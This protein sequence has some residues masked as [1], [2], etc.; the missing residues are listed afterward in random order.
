MLVEEASK[1]KERD[2]VACDMKGNMTKWA[3]EAVV[4]CLVF[5]Y[6]LVVMPMLSDSFYNSFGSFMDLCWLCPCLL[7]YICFRVKCVVLFGWLLLNNSLSAENLFPYVMLGVLDL[8]RWS[9]W[10]KA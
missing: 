4:I 7:N 8:G 10:N 6:L 5:V 9:V 2:G 1:I 3:N